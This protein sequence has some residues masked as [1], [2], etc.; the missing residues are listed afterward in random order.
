MRNLILTLILGC[1]FLSCAEEG[2]DSIRLI[3]KGYEGPVLI[4]FNQSKG[5]P[6]E[7]E[8]GKRVY[9]I[10]ENGILETQFEPNYGIQKHQF[11]YVDSLGNREEIPFV[12]VQEQ[13]SL[14][15][16]KDRTKVY[17]FGESAPGKG[18]GFEPN[19]GKFT[20]PHSREFYIGN[21]LDI[22]KS[23]QSKMKFSRDHIK[24]F[25]IFEDK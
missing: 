5:E 11:F 4:V 24:K 25:R 23:Y 7:Y 8:D 14:L 19:E 20:L 12:I 17:A 6:K 10:P 13:D 22:E 3:P 9:R 1:I 21:L 15:K 18:T 2:E 16:V